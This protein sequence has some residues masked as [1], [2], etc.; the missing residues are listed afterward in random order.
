MTKVFFD[1]P[2]AHNCAKSVEDKTAV[3]GS[4]PE[5]HGDKRRKSRFHDHCE[6]G[7][8]VMNKCPHYP[9]EYRQSPGVKRHMLE[10]TLEYSVHLDLISIMFSDKP[11][12]W[13][14]A[15]SEL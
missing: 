1:V 3:C 4:R 13:Q 12:R 8:L 10:S 2:A 6:P 14:E 7:R 15:A 5:K 11:Q 9:V